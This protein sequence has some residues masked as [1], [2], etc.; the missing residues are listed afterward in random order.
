[1]YRFGSNDWAYVFT[2]LAIGFVIYANIA[3]KKVKES[4]EPNSQ[5]VDTIRIES[6]H[7]IYHEW[8]SVMDSMDMDCGEYHGKEGKS[9][10]GEYEYSKWM[11]QQ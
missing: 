2:I 1:M 7:I 3:Q 9:E 5:P 8:D 4:V 10:Y 11:E 6:D